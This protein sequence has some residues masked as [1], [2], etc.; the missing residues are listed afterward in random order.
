[1]R[2]GKTGAHHPGGWQ[3][4]GAFKCNQYDGWPHVHGRQYRIGL[5]AP[6]VG[7]I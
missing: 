1:M 2:R 3:W 7:R 6:A 5:A 4:R